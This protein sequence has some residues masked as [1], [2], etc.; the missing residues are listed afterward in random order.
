ML[1]YV[2]VEGVH[3]LRRGTA[4]ATLTAA[5]Q[6]WYTY[7]DGKV[8]DDG[9]AGITKQPPT[10][11]LSKFDWDLLPDMWREAR[12]GLGIKNAERSHMILHRDSE[13]G[14]YMTLYVRDEYGSAYMDA[15]N[16]GK[17]IDRNPRE[18]VKSGQ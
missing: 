18:P 3:P 8:E 6:H 10:L 16:K 13:T 15:D 4:L 17:V 12:T 11:D 9:S 14:L 2:A 1:L 7:R 5:V